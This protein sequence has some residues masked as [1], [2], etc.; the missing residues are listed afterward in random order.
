MERIVELMISIHSFNWLS[1][2]TRGGANLMMS[3]WVGLA[4]RPFNSSFWQTLPASIS[5]RKHNK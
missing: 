5:V 2:M 3:P 1:L 4:S